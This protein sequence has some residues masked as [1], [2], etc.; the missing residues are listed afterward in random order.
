MGIKE[1]IKSRTIDD[2]IYWLDKKIKF[3]GRKKE[4]LVQK[5]IN[6]VT[7]IDSIQNFELFKKTISKYLEDKQY[8]AHLCIGAESFHYGHINAIF[9]YA[10]KENEVDGKLFPAV[11]HAVR[12]QGKVLRSSEYIAQCTNMVYQSAYCKKD[13]HELNQKKPVFCIGPYIHYTNSYYDDEKLQEIKRKYGKILLVFPTHYMENQSEEYEDDNIVD[14]VMNMA[15]GQYDTV[16]V[17]AYWGNL[18]WKVYDEFEKRGAILV[19]AGFR[20]DPRFLNRLKTLF[21][22][23][24]IVVSNTIATPWGFCAYMGKT[25]RYIINPEEE[26]GT[27]QKYEVNKND[28]ADNFRYLKL[29]SSKEKLDDREQE[30]F[31]KLY[32]YYCGTDADIKTS[33]EIAA[34]ISIATDTLRLSKGKFNRFDM[35]VMKQLKNYEKNGDTLKARLLLEALTD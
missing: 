16:M 20:E 15:E 19:S 1:W 13:V 2:S 34:I 23:A 7:D 27:I 24:D 22:M 31:Q 10:G 12:Y 6:D 29:L 11:E 32:D 26:L 33:E 4:Q 9:E 30:L 25:F 14:V 5:I 3:S 21:L 8:L 28:F 17:S 35:A 18:D